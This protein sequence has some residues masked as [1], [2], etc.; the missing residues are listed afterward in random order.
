MS[1]KTNSLRSRISRRVFA[2]FAIAALAVS[3]IA[4][5][6]PS[7]V[8]AATACSTTTAPATT[9]GKV[10]Q[11]VSVTTAGTYRVWSRIKAPSTAANSY[12]FNTDSAACY[13]NVGDNTAIPANTWT[14]VNYANGTTTTAIDISLT[15]GSHTLNYIGREADVQLDRV[16]LLSDTGCTPTG[17]GDN[18][19]VTDATGPTTSI[20]APTAGST[21]SG[22]VNINAN[23]TDTSGIAKVEFY[24]DGAL[25]GTDTTSAYSYAWNTTTATNGSHSLTV[26]AYDTVGN[27]TTSTAVSVT[28]NNSTGTVD[29]TAPTVTLAASP[30]TIT[31]GQSTTLTATASDNVGVTKVEFYDSGNFLISTDTTAPY[32][33]TWTPT[34][35]GAK[36]PTAKAYDAAGNSKV[37]AAA[38][39][40][41][42]AASTDTTKP[43]ATITAPVSGA[44]IASGTATAISV[45]ATDNVGVAKVEFYDGTTLLST[46]TT[47]TSGVYRYTWT[48][49]VAGVHSL[50][51]KAYDAAGN[52][53]TSAAV[54]VTIT[55]TTTLPGDV[56][57][58]G[59]VNAID[60]SSLISH[61]GQNYPAADFNKDGTVGSADMAILL[62]KWTW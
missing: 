51:A 19:A 20:T 62:S 5:I 32:T 39:V 1:Q 14:W 3:G 47:G 16:L 30:A 59:R 42:N 29:T 57:G 28:A 49:T 10:S 54:S 56:N 50:T 24:V 34:S 55:T 58:D 4:A 38:S 45:N 37:S 40:T 6:H 48:P 31:L 21:V 33:A 13:Y 60:L 12:Y 27:V 53:A 2:V 18:C 15:A 35:A 36:T 26:K 61:D 8:H 22:T 23:A 17:T 44:S 46:A 41:V 11:T 25:K 52:V 9:Y 43:T 7:Q